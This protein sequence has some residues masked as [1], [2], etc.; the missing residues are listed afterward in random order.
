MEHFYC[1]L[2]ANTWKSDIFPLLDIECPVCNAVFPDGNIELLTKREYDEIM[3]DEN[4]VK[5]ILWRKP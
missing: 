3:A 1:K 4:Q 5:H 2:C